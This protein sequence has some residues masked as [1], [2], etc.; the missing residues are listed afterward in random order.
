MIN[1]VSTHLYKQ[2]EKQDS[3]SVVG[4]MY[5]HCIVKIHRSPFLYMLKMHNEGRNGK[6]PLPEQP[7]C[8]N[9]SLIRRIT[10]S[11]T[12]SQPYKTHLWNGD[13]V[14]P[15]AHKILSHFEVFFWHIGQSYFLA[16]ESHQQRDTVAH[17]V[18]LL[19]FRIASQQV[20]FSYLKEKLQNFLT[21]PVATFFVLLFS[22]SICHE[23]QEFKC[24]GE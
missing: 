10:F 17:I 21:C 19:S 13:D 14:L 9:E 16:G 7:S 23:R 24:T 15:K 6:R 5:L 22:L 4:S 11:S 2:N 12:P 3:S 8:S 1:S 18:S 20:L